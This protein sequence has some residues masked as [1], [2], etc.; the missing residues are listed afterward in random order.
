MFAPGGTTGTLLQPAYQPHSTY[1]LAGLGF[2]VAGQP[3]PQAQPAHQDSRG[4]YW[5]GI[6]G[7][8]VALIVLLYTGTVYNLVFL[9]RILPSCGRAD[10]A[11]MFGC[12]FDPLWFLALWS[13]IQA[14]TSDPG[15]LPERWRQYVA[16]VGMQLP[17]VQAQRTWQF[18]TA[19]I[20][21]KTGLPRPD[22]AHY[23]KVSN[24]NVLR[25]DHYC[26]WL[27]NCVGFKNHKFF[28]LLAIYGA[29]SAV[30]GV[31]TGAPWLMFCIS[32]V[33]RD[34]GQALKPSFSFGEG[35]GSELIGNDLD[36]REAWAF[37]LC[38]LLGLLV[39]VLLTLL[40]FGVVSNAAGNVTTI[41]Q[42]YPRNTNPFDQGSAIGNIAQIF[43]APGPDWLIPVAPW[44]P[45]C[46][47]IVFPTTG[48]PMI[49]AEG[50]ALWHWW[51]AGLKG[52]APTTNSPQRGW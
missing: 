23:C 27:S 51:Y 42:N 48:T 45:L 50:E 46:D 40:S 11:V 33:R 18:G 6:V 9:Y 19:T 12:I 29:M 25:M 7:S 41:E 4:P 44:A 38:S 49:Q 10:L 47:G 21:E 52:H 30:V 37:L 17:V 13:Y 36:L 43:G 31:L 16:Q 26:P 22:R 2:E 20:C 14:A 28:M 32:A 35:L 24:K 3:G 15:Y 34:D 5:P 1:Q 39:A 8:T